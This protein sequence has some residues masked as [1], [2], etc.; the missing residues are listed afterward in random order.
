MFRLNVVD[1]M[2]SNF[3]KEDGSDTYSTTHLNTGDPTFHPT[4][5]F[6]LTESASN[7]ST[8][9]RDFHS[10]AGSQSKYLLG[11]VQVTLLDPC[12]VINYYSFHIIN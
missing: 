3:K 10:T 6:M 5:V 9:K 4:I 1:V 11:S 8:G 2:L 7:L 12:H